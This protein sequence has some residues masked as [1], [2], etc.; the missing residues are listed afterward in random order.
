MP[1]ALSAADAQS[2]FK[3]RSPPSTSAFTS[4]DVAYDRKT[5]KEMTTTVTKEESDK[6]FA[7]LKAKDRENKVRSS[8][9]QITHS[10]KY[11]VVML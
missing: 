8:L 7:V 6:V 5:T 2:T 3:L 11:L 9:S 10:T 4:V 1:D